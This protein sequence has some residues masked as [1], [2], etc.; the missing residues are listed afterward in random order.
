MYK[1]KTAHEDFCKTKNVHV[2]Y[3]SKT[4]QQSLMKWFL[5]TKTLNTS[6]ILVIKHRQQESKYLWLKFKAISDTTF[7][8]ILII[9]KD[10]SS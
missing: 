4:P 2:Q 5:N 3:T 7:L 8:I 9:F 10:K 1:V 6:S